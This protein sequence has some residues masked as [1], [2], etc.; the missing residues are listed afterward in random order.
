MHSK[1]M[2][3]TLLILFL[4]LFVS[5][6]LAW[7]AGSLLKAAKWQLVFGIGAGLMVVALVPLF[8]RDKY[9]KIAALPLC[10]NALACGLLVAA[11]FIGSKT[12]LSLPAA[13]Y[14]ALAASGAYLVF[15]LLLTVPVLRDKRIYIAVVSLLWCAA[16]F[17][18]GGILWHTF[19]AGYARFTLFCI[20]SA[21]F[22]FASL[23]PSQDMEDCFARSPCPLL[24]GG[25][26]RRDRPV[27]S[28]GRRRLRLLRRRGLRRLLRLH[29]RLRRR[30]KENDDER[31]ERTLRG[32][33][34]IFVTCLTTKDEKD[35]RA[36]ALPSLFLFFMRTYSNLS[37]SFRS[38]P[39]SPILMIS[40][41]TL[42]PMLRTSST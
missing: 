19:G 22:A 23:F 2:W 16:L 35:G 11:Y 18:T 7:A 10:I 3:Q 24:R 30:K 31:V 25:H 42:S 37:K 6:L 33:E 26:R 1:K 5:A 38:I 36:V 27:R 41:F 12:A 15:M 32:A 39:F 13:L 9:P 40:T 20:F 34:K 28:G 17:I 21:L 8:L 14:S 29:A 4:F